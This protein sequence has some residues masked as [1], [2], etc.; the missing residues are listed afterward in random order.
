LG[1][2]LSKLDLNVCLMATANGVKCLGP[3]NS[4]DYE[5]LKQHALLARQRGK[6][7]LEKA[8]MEVRTCLCARPHPCAAYD[9]TCTFLHTAMLALWPAEGYTHS[10]RAHHADP[11]LLLTPDQGAPARESR[12]EQRCFLPMFLP[13]AWQVAVSMG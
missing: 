8:E 1:I 13:S 9:P 11:T 5:R 7:Q 4:S 3:A 10:I 12:D 2:G 6:E